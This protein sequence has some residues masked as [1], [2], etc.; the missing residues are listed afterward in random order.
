MKSF[1]YLLAALVIA[2]VA[3]SSCSKHK[4]PTRHNGGNIDKVEKVDIGTIVDGKKVYWATCNLGARNPWEYGDVYAWGELDPKDIYTRESHTYKDTPGTLPLEADAANNAY[5]GKWR[6]PT[7]ADFEALLALDGNED[8]IF[9]KEGTLKDKDGNDV[10][11]LKITRKSTG[12]VLFFPEAGCVNGEVRKYVGSMGW[13]WSSNL[14]SKY[15]SYEVSILFMNSDMFNT[16]YIE[17][18]IGSSI[19]PVLD[20]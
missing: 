15:G 10:N 13:Y 14:Y 2:L 19:R 9:D 6:L 3:L 1:K 20:E 11:G 5:G 8:Y 12:T 7:E 16:G 4:K 17:P 18:F